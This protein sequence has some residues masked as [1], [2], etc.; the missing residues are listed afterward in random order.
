MIRSPLGAVYDE[1]AGR[2]FQDAEPEACKRRILQELCEGR[3]GG[4]LTIR[5]E[6]A[7]PLQEALLDREARRHA[8]ADRR[9][10]SNAAGSSNVGPPFAS[11][12][13]R[14]RNARRKRAKSARSLCWRSSSPAARSMNSRAIA[15]CRGE[16]RK[17]RFTKRSQRR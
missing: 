3:S 4:L 9:W 15:P 13:K 8:M 1:M 2:P 6:A 17:P 12:S 7:K 5:R 16:T 11:G 14:A 10:L